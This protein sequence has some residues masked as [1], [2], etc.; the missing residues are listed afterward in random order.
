MNVKK[1]TFLGRHFFWQFSGLVLFLMTLALSL[2]VWG[3]FSWEEDSLSKNSG[4]SKYTGYASQVE[5][6]F[7]I[8]GFGIPTPE[9]QQILDEMI[10][11][12][13]SEEVDSAENGSTQRPTIYVLMGT[14]GSGKSTIHQ[15]L[16]NRGFIPNSLRTVIAA[17]QFKPKFREYQELLIS[18]SAKAAVYVHRESLLAADIASYLAIQRGVS[19]TLDGSA[20]HLQSQR[21][22]IRAARS[23]GKNY[24]LVLVRI[25]TSV[26]SA[27]KREELRFQDS[28]RRVPAKDILDKAESIKTVFAETAD[29]FD[30]V[31]T[32]SNERHPRIISAIK[33]GRYASF[34]DQ[35]GP[36]K[37][38]DPTARRAHKRDPIDVII[39][40][41][42]T[43][44][45]LLPPSGDAAADP[46]TFRFANTLF[47]FSDYAAQVIF[48]LAR[49]SRFRVSFFSGGSTNRI[50]HML[51]QLEI[52]PGL[53][54]FDV[55]FQILTKHNLTNVSTD[56]SL[57]FSSRFKKDLRTVMRNINLERAILIDDIKDFGPENQHR[58]MLWV[59]HALGYYRD[60]EQIRQ[61]RAE[62][63]D[64]RYLPREINGDGGLLDWQRERQKL[65]YSL[66]VIL[67][68]ARLSQSQGRTPV[69]T[70]NELT[71]DKNGN[72]I[73]REDPRQMRFYEVGRLAISDGDPSG[74]RERAVLSFESPRIGSDQDKCRRHVARF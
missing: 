62:G 54:A 67:E 65:L 68:V 3:D 5:S 25:R 4:G 24:R 55:A 12:C 22:L 57:P 56:S 31:I 11:D 52:L 58:N 7:D 66:G 13:L 47:R 72:L 9:R 71:R 1:N 42:W 37:S 17:D 34:V 36:D 8:R 38:I 19:F 64:S 70:L 39:D 40:I 28:Q 10:E 35:V 6:D 18:N 46:G 41:D 14:P 23:S 33:D 43:L 48:H 26:D 50:E 32:V 61:A 63:A 29:D 59:D 51:R 45:Y 27:L 44:A 30:E 74:R 16:V 2:P 20:S 53:S 15:M 73:S 49:D 69:Q 60:L 21:E